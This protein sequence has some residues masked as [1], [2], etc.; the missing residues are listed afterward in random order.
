M[1][2]KLNLGCGALYLNGFINCDIRKDVGAD[3]VFDMSKGMPFDDGE[4]D[5]IM[6]QDILEH[7]GFRETEKMLTE[8]KRVLKK[9]GLLTVQV[10][11]IDKHIKDYWN[12]RNDKRYVN[13]YD[14]AF[15]FMRA[16]IFGGQD[17]EGNFHKTCFTPNTLRL[18]LEKLGFTMLS[19]DTHDRAIIAVCQK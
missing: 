8:W 4:A 3:K 5:E 13:G 6:A 7:F 19:L 11:N 9:G 15:E 12:D 2:I 17:Y 10:P 16:N 14:N 18:V 1:S